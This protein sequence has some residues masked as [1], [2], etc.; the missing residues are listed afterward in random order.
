MSKFDFQDVCSE[1]VEFFVLD[2]DIV[3]VWTSQDMTR[4]GVAGKVDTKVI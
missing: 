2:V 1:L 3:V 4:I